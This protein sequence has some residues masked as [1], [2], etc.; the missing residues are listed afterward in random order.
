MENLFNKLFPLKCVNCGKVGEIICDNC[1][2]SCDLLPIQYCIVCDKPSFNGITHVKCKDSNKNAPEQVVSVYKYAKVVRHSIKTSKYGYKQFL[3]LKK[4]T[5]EG[6][7]VLKEW[8][9]DFKDFICVPVPTTNN[10]YIKR[11]FNQAEIIA[12]IFSKQL[13]LPMYINII[14]RERETKAQYYLGRKNRFENVKD[15]FKVIG[16]VSGK[17]I[18]VVDDIVTTGATLLEISRILYDNG[19]HKVLGFTLSKK[20]KRKYTGA[21]GGN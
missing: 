17:N 19:A 10:K 4:M 18:L 1:L 6:I 12:E 11:G 13:H 20:M 3:A 5:Y 15:A 2:Y 9:F 7:K 16:N 14:K 21:P 8:G